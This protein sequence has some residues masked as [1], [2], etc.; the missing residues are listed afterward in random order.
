MQQTLQLTSVRALQRVESTYTCVILFNFHLNA[1]KSY[2]LH[3]TVEGK[4]LKEV[5]Q[6]QIAQGWS[7]CE[8]KAGETVSCSF[9]GG[10][11]ITEI[12]PAP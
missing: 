11:A 4:K 6:L 2:F 7:E 5:G 10:A 3:F 1:V 12:P 8:A 9:G